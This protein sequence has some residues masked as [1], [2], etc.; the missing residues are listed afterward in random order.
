MPPKGAT[1]IEI[2][3]GFGRLAN[4][5]KGYDKVVLFDYSRSLL[6]EAQ[7]HLGDDHRYLYVAGNFYQ[8]PFVSGL[9]DT[10]VQVRS[11]HHASDPETLF[12]QVSRVARPKGHY[13][14]EYANKRNLKAILRYALMR[15]KWSPFELEPYEFL[16]VH[17]DFHP[18]WIDKQL[19]AYGFQNQ[20]SIPV[21]FFRIALLKRSIP[22]PWLVGLDGLMQHLG[23]LGLFSPSVFTC[24]RFKEEGVISKS[25]TFFACPQCA[26]P[27][28]DNDSLLVCS[29]CKTGWRKHD[30]LYDFKEPIAIEERRA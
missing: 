17:F 10:I 3:A 8:L 24:N 19:K 27:I 20:A 11:L 13:I 2:G 23:R 4:E 25:D 9:F 6:R 15:Q 26:T 14:L 28:E 7:A 30:G 21:S 5:Y 12:Q 16:P 22:L 1:L 29:K 18:K